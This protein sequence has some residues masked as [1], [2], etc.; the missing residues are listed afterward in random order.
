MTKLSLADTYLVLENEVSKYDM[1]QIKAAFASQT[2]IENLHQLRHQL[3]LS[4]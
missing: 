2:V 3:L 4:R 1:L